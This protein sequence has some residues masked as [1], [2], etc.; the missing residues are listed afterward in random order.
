MNPPELASNYIKSRKIIAKLFGEEWLGSGGNNELQLLWKKTDWIALTE[1]LIFGH[2]LENCWLINEN[3]TK[4]FVETIKR[5]N[6]RNE[7]RGSIYEIIVAGAYYDEGSSKVEFP[8]NPNNPGYDLKLIQDELNIYV[9]IKTHGLFQRVEEFVEK[10]KE[11]ESVVT[12]NIN[13]GCNAV[14]IVNSISYP[15]LL[16]WSSLQEYLPKFLNSDSKMIDDKWS[17][18][19]KYATGNKLRSIKNIVSNGSISPEMASYILFLTTKLHKNDLRNLFDKIDDACRNFEIYGED[20]SNSINII[21]IRVPREID[22]ESCKIMIDDYF[23]NYKQ[24]SKVS[25]IFLYQPEFVF[26]NSSGESLTHCYEFII[27]PNKQDLKNINIIPKFLCG[28]MNKG[29]APIMFVTGINDIVSKDIESYKYQSGRI[30]YMPSNENETPK[31]I[32]GILM[33]PLISPT[34]TNGKSII[35][36]QLLPESDAL[37]LL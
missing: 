31:I 15:D 24:S 6:N 7:R 25:G 5:S 34:P 8:P 21:F 13:N 32:N 11:I 35:R 30:F 27:N 18:F 33:E 2:C 29:S 36:R 10:S 4:Y 9:S 19:V 12:Q 14:F 16:D 20:D 22:L 17:I 26:I 3:R 37:L 1:L 23:E 28:L